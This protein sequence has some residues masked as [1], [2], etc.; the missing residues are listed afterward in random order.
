LGVILAVA[1]GKGGTGK[2]TV[3]VNMAR[4]LGS[5][6]RLL[7]CDVEEPN[8]HLFLSGALREA[9]TVGIPVPRVD[10]SLCDGCGECGRLCEYHAIVSFGTKPLIFPEL[11]H[12]CGGCAKV[13]PKK[14]IHEVNKRIGVVETVQAG[15]IT[16]IHGRL[17]VG[18]AMAPPLIRAVK[19]RLQSGLPA[20]LDAPPGTACPVIATLRGTDFVVLVTEPTPFGLHD[21]KLAVDMV[22]ELRIPFGVVVNRVGIGDDRV[23]AFCR[24]ENIA[25]LLEIPEDRRIAEAYSKG[26]LIVEALPEY[27]GLFQCLIEKTVNLKNAEG[28]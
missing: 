12:G 16:L 26:S 23:H 18:M 4:V 14:A 7:D 10:E 28:F 13:C 22:R 24:Q 5:E 11:C 1:S 15:N 9:E 20:I 21:L 8:D 25:V 6:V 17:D 27:R 19:A 3:S 2:T